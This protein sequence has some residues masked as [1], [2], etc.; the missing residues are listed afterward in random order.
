MPFRRALVWAAAPL[1]LA[2]ATA[3]EVSLCADATYDLPLARGALCSGAG[4]TPSGLACPLKGDVASSD[5]SAS[6]PSFEAGR[7]VAPED[8]ECRI[9][10]GGAWGCVL[11]SIGCGATSEPSVPESPGCPAWDFDST[12]EVADRHLAP[13]ASLGSEDSDPSWF[14]QMTPLRPMSSVGDDDYH[15]ITNDGPTN[16]SPT[17]NSPANNSTANDCAINDCATHHGSANI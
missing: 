6:L 15:A 11:P 5:C 10:S 4:E 3:L 1:L 7:C 12:A 13:L 14:V 17:N 9:V 16:D 8:G 2:R